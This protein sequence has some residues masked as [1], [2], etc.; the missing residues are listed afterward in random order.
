MKLPIDRVR[1]D[2]GKARAQGPVVLS[3]P[4]GSGKSTAVPQWCAEFGRVVVV[5]PRRVACRSL[6]R[7]VADQSGSVLGERVG[8]QVRDDRSAT[9]D[10]QILFVTPG[11]ALRQLAALEA[12]DTVILDEFHERQMEVDLL[13][14]LLH[15]HPGLTV[16]SATIAGDA[17]AR[18]LGGTHVVVEGRSFPIEIRYRPGEQ[19]APNRQQLPERVRDAIASLPDDDDGDVLVFLPGKAEI[20]QCA[21][22][23]EG[24]RDLDV[25][26]LHGGLSPKAQDEVLRR[27]GGD[28]R[29]VILSTNV[30]ETSLTVPGIRT[31]IDSGL[32]RRTHYDAG[33]SALGLSPIAQD[34]ADQRAGRAGR[35]GPGRAIRLWDPATALKARTPPE[36]HRSAL[37]EWVLAIAVLRPEPPVTAEAIAQLPFFDPPPDHALDA[38]IAALEHWGAVEN[39]RATALGRR[40][41]QLPVD[42]AQGRYLIA[43]SLAPHQRVIGAW[44]ALQSEGRPIFGREGPTEDFREKESDF[45][46]GVLGLWANRAAV[47]GMNEDVFRGARTAAGRWAKSG[48]APGQGAPPTSAELNAALQALVRFDPTL[49]HAPRTRGR[50]IVY[51]NGGTEIAL[52]RAS[53]VVPSDQKLVAILGLRAELHGT[54]TTLLATAAAPVPTAW[55]VDLKLGDTRV[56]AVDYRRGAVTAEVERVYAQ[57]VLDRF[58]TTPRGALLRDTVLRLLERRA[59]PLSRPKTLS[60]DLKRLRLWIALADRGEMPGHTPAP[61]ASDRARAALDEDGWLR[62]RLEQAGLESSDELPLLDDHD[63][64]LPALPASVQ[65]FLADNYP[66][67]LTAGSA[68]YE[69]DYDLKAR[70]ASLFVVRGRNDRAPPRHYLPRLPGFSIA[71]QAGGTLHHYR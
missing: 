3:A 25:R 51:S 67:R 47:S 16:M 7:F 64:L 39:G 15:D 14:A 56:R 37:A 22:R 2:Y 38:A 28:K 12:S 18:H 32:V 71:I 63:L 43:P 20:A 65:D 54:R 23:L 50:H 69:V 19:R 34:S 17:L 68:E 62:H 46:A 60:V 30:A 29:R 57:M 13:L 59:F 1:T 40:L 9:D 49:I 31:V 33:R 45:H 58:E 48:A 10:T 35:L 41:F 24:Q 36:I 5:E 21:R 44:V 42:A 70:R 6:A 52:D 26:S 4:T 53:I 11:I 61:T 55:A 8:Y 66:L 27:R